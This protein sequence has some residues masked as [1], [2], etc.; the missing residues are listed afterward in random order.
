[1][2]NNL[3]EKS[4]FWVH[5]WTKWETYNNPHYSTLRQRRSCLNCG[6]TQDKLT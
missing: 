4:C 1:M 3:K 5:K 2:M 6:L